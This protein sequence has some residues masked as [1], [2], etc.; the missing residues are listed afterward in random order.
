MARKP[1]GY[2]HWKA[3]AVKLPEQTI[4]ELRRYSNLH[5][6]SVSALIRQ[7]LDMRLHGPQQQGDSSG[8]TVIPDT[9]VTMLTR[10]ATTLSIVA[11]QLRDAC[12]SALISDE[13]TQQSPR[14]AHE[15][16]GNAEYN[17]KTVHTA[18]YADAREDTRQTTSAPFDTSKFYLG[19]L[20]GKGH[21]YPGTEQSLRR[22]GKRD[23]VKCE[24][25]RR[26]RRY[27]NSK[28]ARAS[29]LVCGPALRSATRQA[30]GV[31]GTPSA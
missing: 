23:C 2:P 4:A 9:T 16:N 31:A 28:A 12:G 26:Q 3:L 8:N 15:Y 1:T 25:A 5:N 30:M 18:P 11:E 21:A 29:S 17:G 13:E 22:L 7:A 19:D 27:E 10:L 20:C 14:A 6:I 24:A